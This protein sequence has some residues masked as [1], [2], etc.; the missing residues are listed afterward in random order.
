MK[1]K[2]GRL[3]QGLLFALL[4]AFVVAAGITAYLT[5]TVVRDLIASWELTSLPGV[6]IQEPAAVAPGETPGAPAAGGDIQ[7][8]LQPLGGPTPQPWDKASRVNVLV[9]GL[10]YGDWAADRD[11]PRTDT[12]I[13]FTID[14]LA[15]TAGMVSIPRDMWVNI[16][17]YQYNRINTAYSLGE[18]TEY[19]GGGPGLAMT[20]VEEF[21]GTP[22]DYYALIDFMAFVRFIDEIGGVKVDVPEA[23]TVDPIGDNNSKKLKPGRQ[24]LPG[25]LAL[26]YARTRKTEGADFDRAQRTQQVIM[27]IR[28]R[29]LSADMLPQLISKS[30]VLYQELSSGVRTNLSLEQIIQLAWL[31]SQIPQES[32][33]NGAISPPDQ[34]LLVTTSD[35]QQVLKPIADQIRLL[36]DDVFFG[37]Q[38]LSPAAAGGSPLDLLKAE[39][40]KIILMNGT[41]E[42]GLAARTMEFLLAQGVSAEAGNA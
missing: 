12:M 27:A 24:T 21:L 5:Y 25:D 3:S 31:A 10:D 41:A 11:D 2:P 9:M 32:I 8:P 1:T 22:V 13:L 29:I 38:Y 28:D 15:R 37:E 19:P 33:R 36:R 14:P 4:G 39:G 34:V 40:A 26:A 35:G 20:T 6:T 17:G 7:S 23:I 42:A 16:P 30:P 18:G